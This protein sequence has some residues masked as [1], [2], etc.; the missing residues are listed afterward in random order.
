MDWIHNQLNT[1]GGI[2]ENG[3]FTINGQFTGDSMADFMLG[4]LSDFSQGNPTG[5]TSARTTSACTA[6]TIYG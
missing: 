6:R 2:N 1:V 5:G 3:V 4:L